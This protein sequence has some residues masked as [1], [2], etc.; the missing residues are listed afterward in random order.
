VLHLAG[1]APWARLLQD[2]ITA[3]RALPAPG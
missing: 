2:A 1:H 3:V